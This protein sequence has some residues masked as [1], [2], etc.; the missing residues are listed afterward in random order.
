MEKYIDFLKER[1]YKLTNQRKL[2]LKI[3]YESTSPLTLAEIH[4]K[5]KKKIDFSSVY[6][7]VKLFSEI[8][9]VN[10]FNA[11][12]KNFRYELMRSSKHVHHIICENCGNILNL[13]VCY[14]KEIEKLTK[15]KILKHSM[16]FI[17]LC[18]DCQ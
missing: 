9:L 8:K 6:R 5:S 16:E 2:V 18:P 17:G 13:D 15:Y 1:G 10:E 4:S 7:I 11:G 14:S 12:D 3:M